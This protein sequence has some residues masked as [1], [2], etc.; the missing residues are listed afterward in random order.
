M[1]GYYLCVATEKVCP[2]CCLINS[3]S[4]KFLPRRERGRQA[5]P[6]RKTYLALNKLS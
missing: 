3:S 2:S 1:A 6:E 4:I 5:E